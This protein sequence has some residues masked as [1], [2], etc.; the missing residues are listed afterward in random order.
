KNKLSPDQV[1]KLQGLAQRVEILWKIATRRLQIAEFEARRFI[2]HWPHEREAKG[3][4]VTREKIEQSL[5]NENGAYRRLKRVMDAWTALW[6]WPLTEREVKPPTIDEWISAVEKILGTQGKQSKVKGQ[7][8]LDTSA[9][10]EELNKLEELELQ[11]AFAA[12]IDE[13]LFEAYPW[14]KTTERVALEQ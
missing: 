11:F 12:I 3:T 2:N 14:L 10:W 8:T 7:F 6:Y 1:K 13:D 5:V 4:T 9:D